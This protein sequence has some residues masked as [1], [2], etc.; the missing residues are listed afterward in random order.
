[1]NCSGVVWMRNLFKIEEMTVMLK[2]FIYVMSS[3]GGARILKLGIPASEKNPIHS[4]LGFK[5]NAYSWKGKEA[6]NR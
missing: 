1:M 6:T 2:F 3:S 4:S 5:S